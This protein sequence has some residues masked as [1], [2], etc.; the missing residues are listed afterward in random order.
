LVPVARLAIPWVVLIAMISFVGAPWANRQMTDLRQRF[1]AREDVAQIAPGRF[2][3]SVAASRVFVESVDESRGT[4]GN[5]FVASRRGEAVTVIASAAGRI[6]AGRF[7]AIPGSGK[8]RQY[9]GSQPDTSG[10][11][12]CG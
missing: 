9:D 5:V 1:D 2:R 12:R 8:G 6:R 7:R 3:E 10:P 11:S 4:V